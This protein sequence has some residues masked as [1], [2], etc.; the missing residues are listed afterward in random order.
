MARPSGKKV[1]A[2]RPRRSQRAYEDV[3]R[4]LP[5]APVARDVHKFVRTWDVGNLATT[6]GDKGFLFNAA[7]SDLPQYTEF[8][9]LFDQ[10][11]F[12]Q[13][14]WVFTWA[15]ASG[16]TSVY[17]PIMYIAPDY[18][19]SAGTP[20][21]LGDISQRRHYSASFNPTH[22][23]HSFSVKPRALLDVAGSVAGLHPANTWFDT[24]SAG[25]IF[26]GARAWIANYNNTLG[27]TIRCEVR[28][29][30]KFAGLL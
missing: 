17:Y 15:D 4:I 26:R 6:A 12:E 5:L 2:R 19:S 9:A 20:G 21:S 25:T 29:H 24:A 3:V 28:V 11:N 30:C 27:G 13:I 23:Q 1:R 7:L 10:F 18:D 16:T 14:T 22:T 8:S